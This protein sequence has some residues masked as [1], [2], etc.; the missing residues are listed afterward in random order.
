MKMALVFELKGHY[1][2]LLVDFRFT[3]KWMHC[4]NGAAQSVLLV[5]GIG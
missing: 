2:T 1:L 4:L 3:C 5:L